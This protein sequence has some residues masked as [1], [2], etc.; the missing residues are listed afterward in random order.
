MRKAIILITIGLLGFAAGTS[1]PRLAASEAVSG[2]GRQKVDEATMMK[3]IAGATSAL[4]EHNILQHIAFDNESRE[5]VRNRRMGVPEELLQAKALMDAVISGL[6]GV[7]AEDPRLNAWRDLLIENL[8]KVSS[9]DATNIQCRED[10]MRRVES[11]AC[12]EKTAANAGAGTAI[13][14]IA[15]WERDELLPA[16]QGECKAFYGLFPETTVR[17]KE[18]EALTQKDTFF[19]FTTVFDREKK[20]LVV[21]H[22][23][24]DTDAEKKGTQAGDVVVS[25]NGMRDF[26]SKLDQL[27]RV[28]KIKSGAKVSL[29]LQRGQKEIPI[30]IKA[31]SGKKYTKKIAQQNAKTWKEIAGGKKKA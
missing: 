19:G 29:I 13:G 3:K 12:S 9:M 11:A 6:S 10:A 20:Q 1:V 26:T 18:Y 22:V 8:S 21:R 24:M 30:T 5:L 28:D 23:D 2:Q 14:N 27:Q 4:I 31:Q 16:L 15:K 17:R 25:I 7:A